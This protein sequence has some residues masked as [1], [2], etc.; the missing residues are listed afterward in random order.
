[1]DA[2]LGIEKQTKSNILPGKSNRGFIPNSSREIECSDSS[3]K[4]V[5][6][7]RCLISRAINAMC[8]VFKANTSLIY[9]SQDCKQKHNQNPCV[10]RSSRASSKISYQNTIATAAFSNTGSTAVKGLMFSPK[11]LRC[12]SC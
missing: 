6:C 9:V 5:N 4:T 3:K 11:L 8:Y 12:I 7:L 2:C 1:M 10:N